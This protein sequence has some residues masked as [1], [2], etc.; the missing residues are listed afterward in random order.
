MNM[1]KNVVNLYRVH[2][3]AILLASMDAVS[4]GFLVSLPGTR[5]VCG[6][7]CDLEATTCL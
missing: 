1:G 6:F 7:F 3:G 5:M 2:F 4:V